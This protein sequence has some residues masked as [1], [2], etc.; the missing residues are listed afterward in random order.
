MNRL[1]IA[2]RNSKK[3]REI[4]D[5][6]KDIDIQILTLNDFPHI[7][8]IRE[9]GSTFVENTLHKARTVFEKTKLPALGDDS[10]LEVYYMNLR[11]GVFSARY[12]GGNTSQEIN[13]KK[14]LDELRGVPE[15]R[16][17]ARFRC[18]LA[19]VAA[20]AEN[21]VEGTC[22]GKIVLSPRGSKGF[23]YDPLFVPSGYPQTF[24]ELEPEIKNGISHRAKALEQI[25]P[26]LREFFTKLG[27]AP[28]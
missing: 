17:G 16:R 18:V 26:V 2:T 20:G 5:I 12:A 8:R 9:D 22:T 25:R 13:N 15:R 4:R 28:A 21:V 27:E 1:V 3:A 6:L 19:F 23:G 14:L 7:D 10:G 11:P 24:G